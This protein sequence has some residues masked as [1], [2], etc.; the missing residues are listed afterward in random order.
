MLYLSYAKPMYLTNKQK[1]KYIEGKVEYINKN[2]SSSS[3]MKK[4]KIKI[5]IH[6]SLQYYILIDKS[7]RYIF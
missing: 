1:Q 6:N 3:G 7:L 4:N 5:D 2:T